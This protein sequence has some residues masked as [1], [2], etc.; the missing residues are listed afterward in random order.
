MKQRQKTSAEKKTLETR[1]CQAF[2]DL[3][4]PEECRDFLIDLCTPAEIEAMAD[5]WEVVRRLAKKESYRTISE[6]TSVSLATIG[7]VA[8]CLAGPQNGYRR[9]L[10][11]QKD[12]KGKKS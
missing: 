3:K 6:K 10:E 5:R 11:R 7:R 8:R 2:L 12:A 4:T 1:L 9:V